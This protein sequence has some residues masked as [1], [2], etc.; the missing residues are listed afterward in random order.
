MSISPQSLAK[1]RDKRSLRMPSRFND[2]REI[3]TEVAY[4][5][6]AEALNLKG[7]EKPVQDVI[8]LP[9]EKQGTNLPKKA[10]SSKSRKKSSSAKKTSSS[11]K[12]AKNRS[13]DGPSLAAEEHSNSSNSSQDKSKNTTPDVND[14]FECNEKTLDEIDIKPGRSSDTTD[15]L[16]LDTSAQESSTNTIISPIKDEDLIACSETSPQRSTHPSQ[17]ATP[18]ASQQSS[19]KSTKLSKESQQP[20]QKIADY[21]RGKVENS[22]HELDP[23]LDDVSLEVRNTTIERLDLCINKSTTNK[24]A[25]KAKRDRADQ[26]G[27][28]ADSNQDDVIKIW[29]GIFHPSVMIRKQKQPSSGDNKLT[30]KQPATAQ[31]PLV[32][33]KPNSP[34]VSMPAPQSS[35]LK[36]SLTPSRKK[37][38]GLS[39]MAKPSRPQPNQQLQHHQNSQILQTSIQTGNS[40]KLAHQNGYIYSQTKHLNNFTPQSNVHYGTRLLFNEPIYLP[41]SVGPI[42]PITATLQQIAAQARKPPFL[43][44]RYEACMKYQSKLIFDR[45]TSMHETLVKIAK[46]L[47]FKDRMNLRCVN[48]AWKSVIDSES[49]WSEVVLSDADS[50]LDLNRCLE[51]LK[52]QTKEIV[53]DNFGPIGKSISVRKLED[54]ALDESENVIRDRFLVF[55]DKMEKLERVT[56]KSMDAKRNTIAKI[57]VE[58]ALYSTRGATQRRRGP[59]SWC[60]KVGIDAQGVATVP[61]VGNV[62]NR[63]V[64][65]GED[66]FNTSEGYWELEEQFV[67]KF[68]LNRQA[69]KEESKFNRL[70]MRP[71]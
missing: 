26:D 17:S 67:E 35:I 18:A 24:S 60:V 21:S 46:Q 37:P 48:R 2:F 11:S 69:H 59:V 51:L 8:E 33:Q 3:P 20:K 45:I 63:L 68:E 52:P 41:K 13:N 16:V 7:K 50:D 49:V 5:D 15:E 42:A 57:I 40:Q 65:D 4:R 44:K 14:T 47:G 43:S 29:K 54:I 32:E 31:F 62:Y 58:A 66:N 36:A 70:H 19:S 25:S 23:Q 38:K 1:T 30:E 22:K 39:L 34:A 53:F 64:L 27:D 55:F 71:I 28:S 12:K 10:S 61:M 6:V 56:V 9:K